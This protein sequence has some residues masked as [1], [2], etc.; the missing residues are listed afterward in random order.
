M[1]SQSSQSKQAP[2]WTIPII[3]HSGKGKTVEI[4]KRLEVARGFTGR[5]GVESVKHRV[6]FQA[7]KLF[8]EIHDA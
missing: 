6:L 2:Y 5:K 8:C 1:L 7:V 4:G 3:R